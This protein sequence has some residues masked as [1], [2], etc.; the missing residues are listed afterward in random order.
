IVDLGRQPRLGN[1][2]IRTQAVPQLITMQK[3]PPGWTARRLLGIQSEASIEAFLDMS[4]RGG[5]PA[6]VVLSP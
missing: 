2:L 5:Q 4:R 1:R 3:E 6:K